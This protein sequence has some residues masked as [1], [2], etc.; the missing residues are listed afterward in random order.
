MQHRICLLAIGLLFVA[1]GVCFGQQERPYAREK[2]G[3]ST[4]GSASIGGGIGLLYGGFGSRFTYH[5]V[6]ELGLFAGLGYNLVSLGYNVGFMYSFPSQKQT[7]F[8]VTGMYGY[9][10]VIRITGVGGFQESY[11]GPSTGAGLRLNSNRRRG[12]YWDFGL[13]LPFRSHAF[14]ESFRIAQSISD[15]KNLPPLLF[16][17]GYHIPLNSVRP[18]D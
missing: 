18:S 9:N 3:T 13:L 11:R 12:Q 14:E 7:T 8:F 16:F 17:A 4:Q 6:D 10:A 15:I 5:P 1:H 2:Y